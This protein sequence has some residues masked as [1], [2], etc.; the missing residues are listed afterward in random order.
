MKLYELVGAYQ[1]IAEML[2]NQE[3]D[4]E[5]IRQ[6]LEQVEGDFDKKVENIAKLIKTMQSE[7]KALKAEEMRL[8][9]RRKSIES[10][11]QW[12]RNYT[13]Q[14][15]EALNKKKIKTPLFTIYTQKSHPRVNIVNED[16]IPGY[17]KIP[18][19]KIDS[20]AI[21]EEWKMGKQIPGVRI[22]QSETLQ[23]R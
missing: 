14:Q 15:M 13:Q 17:F 7:A 22:E 5:V 20:R 3:V 9:N 6:A 19:I 10:H 18:Q 4:Q 21:L 2:D 8:A 11:I 23:I 16:V 12:L 1:N